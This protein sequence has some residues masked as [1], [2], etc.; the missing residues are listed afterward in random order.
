MTKR[1]CKIFLFAVIAGLSAFAG[2][3]F[4]VRDSNRSFFVEHSGIDLPFGVTD[5]FHFT[6]FEFAMT[7]HYTLPSKARAKLVQQNPFTTIRSKEW[8]PIFHLAD[9]PVPWNQVPTSGTLFYLTGADFY[10]AWDAVFHLESGGLWTSIHYADYSGDLPP[11]VRPTSP[12]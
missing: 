8:E 4:F 5:T 10:T 9:L 12:N 7:S 2:W 6:E 3:R 1:K 11:R